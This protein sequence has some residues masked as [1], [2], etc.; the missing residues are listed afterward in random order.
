MKIAVIGAR[1]IPAKYGGIE[2]YCQELYPQIVTRG[3]QVDIYVQASYHQQSW[4]STFIYQKMKI[5]ALPSFPGKRFRLLNAAINTIWATFGNYD[6]IHIHGTAAAWFAWFAQIFSSSSIIMTC[7]QLDNPRRCD[8]AFYW[9]Q[10]WLE[11]MAVTYTDEIIVTSQERSSY[12][13]R[14]YGVCSQY[15]ANAPARYA[16][17]NNNFSCRRAFGLDRNHYL[18][19]SGAFEPDCRLDL[20]IEVF[21]KLKLPNWKLVLAGDVSRSFEYSIKLLKM[22]KQQ[23]N[24]IFTGE[25]GGNF[26]EELVCGADIFVNPAEG[27]NLS[28]SVTMLEAMREGIPVIASDTVEHR[29]LIGSDRGLLFRSGFDSLFDRLEYAMSKP[30]RLLNMAKKAQTH[31]AV[32]HNWDRVIYQNL[33]LYLQLTTKVPLRIAT[34]NHR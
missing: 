34:A 23:E 19:Y 21:Q 24:I 26:L 31:I 30:N 27:S 9:L 1:G 29:Q 28:S 8:R 7:H 22:A 13:F 16:A 18:L 32:H 2:R 12:F 17:N 33:F 5:I 20:L 25:I 6:V 11:K 10:P 3:H 14:K 15:I 4:F